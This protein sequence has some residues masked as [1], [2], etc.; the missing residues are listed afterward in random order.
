M[1]SIYSADMSRHIANC[2]PQ[3]RGTNSNSWKR[4]EK[5]W[6]HWS[7]N[8]QL[9]GSVKKSLRGTSTMVFNK[10]NLKNYPSALIWYF[11]Q[12][13]LCYDP[14]WQPF[15][16]VPLVFPVYFK[17]GVISSQSCECQAVHFVPWLDCL[18]ASNLHKQSF[19][20]VNLSQVSRL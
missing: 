16:N 18:I 9:C 2:W 7:L 4:H 1:T 8:S 14:I 19:K 17:A 13:I 5:R 12:N 10:S 11:I 15:K 6:P 20:N 3:G